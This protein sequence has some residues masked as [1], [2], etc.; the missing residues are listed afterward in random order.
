M[1]SLSF[2]NLAQEIESLEGKYRT[3]PNSEDTR[4]HQTMLVTGFLK[5]I[6][7]NIY[8]EEELKLG[9]LLLLTKIRF[10]MR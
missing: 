5:G 10:E 8:T 3:V 6:V 4:K 7:D 9:S 2:K 1:N